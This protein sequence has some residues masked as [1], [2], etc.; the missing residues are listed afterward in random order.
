MNR[1]MRS[2]FWKPSRRHAL[3]AGAAFMF[4]CSA[5]ALPSDPVRN[6]NPEEPT[7]PGDVQNPIFYVLPVGS[8]GDLTAVAPEAILQEFL[9]KHSAMNYPAAVEAAMRLVAVVPDRPIGHYNLACALARMQRIDE[10][11][12]ALRLAIDCGWRDAVHLSIDPD[13]ASLR[14]DQRY[15]AIVADL[16]A[17]AERERIVPT[18]LRTDA[19]EQIAAD[20]TRETPALLA[21]DH[22]PGAAIALIRDGEVVWSAAFGRRDVRSEDALGVDD[23][24]RLRAP[25]HLL[26]ISACAQLEQQSRLQLAPLIVE[27]ADEHGLP[28][29][30]VAAGMGS[31]AAPLAQPA[32]MRDDGGRRERPT[33]EKVSSVRSGL[34]SYSRDSAYG[35]LRLAIE[36]AA[37]QPFPR[38]CE[39]SIFPE[40]G[41]A[42]SSFA[43]PAEPARQAVGHSALGTPLRPSV[44]QGEFAPGGCLYT[45]AGDVARLIASGISP[46]VVQD[47]EPLAMQNMFVPEGGDARV[48]A[49]I[50]MVTQA[51]GAMN[52]SLGLALQR[53]DDA[54]GGVR[55]QLDEAASGIILLARWHQPSR[56]GVV[57]LCNA[58]TGRDAAE[59]IAHL[60]LGGE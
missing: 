24:F 54:D 7:R 16:K 9:D 6:L 17:R 34:R 20:L 47:S 12:D 52:G 58:A 26:A 29:P 39:E 48:A 40:I 44:L 32:G 36:E 19:W 14:S 46:S 10:A 41:L 2:G 28:F 11:I 49:A 23:R 22:V 42:R 50:D 59:R 25:L 15:A 5:A 21:R 51:D 30:P 8:V 43:A 37:G 31:P 18:A 55:F 1:T 27:A 45:T 60:A 38:F 3:A 33:I 35:F 57:V 4:A 13:L 56:S 53:C